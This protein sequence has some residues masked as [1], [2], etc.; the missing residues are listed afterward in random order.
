MNL[1]ARN[2]ILYS[3]IFCKYI[4]QLLSL[5]FYRK[6]ELNSLKNVLIVLFISL[7]FISC[8]KE[9]PVVEYAPAYKLV[10]NPLIPSFNGDN[11][12]S[13]VEK[14]VRFGPRNPNSIGH[15]LAQQ[16][17]VDELRKFADQI[18]EQRFEYTG[19]DNEKLQLNNIIARFNPEEKN[20]IFFAAHWDTRPRAEKEIDELKQK[21][22]ILG[23]NDGGSGVGVLLELARVLKENKVSY[24]IDIILFDGEDYGLNHD[25]NN[26]CLGSKY[27]AVNRPEN[28]TPHFGVLLDLVGDK[29][30]KFFK[31]GS[32]VKYAKDIVD[33]V[34]GV[35][36]NIQAERFSNL[37]S[38]PI[39]D[40]HVPLNQ[41]GIK[42]IDII[43]VDLI[44]ADTGNE[45]RNYWHTLKDDMSNISSETLQEVG[46]VVTALIYKLEFS[47][48]A[49]LK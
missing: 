38:N 19:Y 49:K 7:L 32:S 26:F 36:E 23:A 5:K 16:Y 12:F 20:R 21:L 44:G 3:T 25:L 30:A 48:P 35:A 28:F 2:N 39:Y 37:E 29:E 41:A 40:D 17:L 47:K 10:D 45:R 13:Y 24:G 14:Q 42:T 9:Q 18:I 27:F 31:E 33:F 11:A 4:N 1:Y 15:R 22:P 43:D 8:G 46:N 6:S 34:W